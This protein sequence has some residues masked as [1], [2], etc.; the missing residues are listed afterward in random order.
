MNTGPSRKLRAFTLIE[1]L[2]VIAIIAILAGL[3]LPALARAKS[4]AHRTACISNLKQVGVGLRMWAN[5][6]E[7]QFPWRVE[8]ADGGSSL[9]PPEWVDHFRSCSNELVTPKVLVCPTDRAKTALDLWTFLAGADNVS[10]FVGLSAEESKPQTLLSGDAGNLTGGGGGL[11]PYWTLG[12]ADSID[13]EW[14]AGKSHGRDGQVLLSDGSV[15]TMNTPALRE[16]IFLLLATGSTNVQ[17]SLPNGT[18]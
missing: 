10:Y 12:V 18:L 15:Q 2:V 5:D 7:G 4:K 1:L 11:E 6:N 3:L 13:A 14:T 16:H 17:I 9:T 8:V